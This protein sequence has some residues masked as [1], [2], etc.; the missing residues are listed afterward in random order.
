[1]RKQKQ[2]DPIPDEFSTYEE[3][4]EFWDTHDTTDY[5]DAF[6]T[7]EVKSELRK[8]H[9]EVEI[10]LDVMKQLRARARRKR[11]SLGNLASDLLRQQLSS[12]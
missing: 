2:I 5:P 12:K 10:D 4:A 9:C 1:M 6:R 7:V 11:V 3:A 8:R